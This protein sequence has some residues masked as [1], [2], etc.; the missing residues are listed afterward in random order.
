MFSEM[1]ESVARPRDKRKRWALVISAVSQAGC[2][3]TLV[4]IPLIYTQALPK[5]ILN[6][7]LVGFSEPASQPP[8]PAPARHTG[9]NATRILNH[10][11]VV[12]PPRERTAGFI[13]SPASGERSH[14]C[15]AAV[16]L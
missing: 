15:S 12:E 1:V 6:T 9:V 7:V 14:R 13:R 8:A 10:G 4:L 16:A 11:I 2:L 3:L 5:V